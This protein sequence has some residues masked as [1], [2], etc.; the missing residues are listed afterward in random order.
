MHLHCVHTKINIPP[1][2]N[3]D[4]HTRQQ[5][6]V[7]V[8]TPLIMGASRGLSGHRPGRRVADSWGPVLVA[9]LSLN[10]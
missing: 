1:L 3:A 9:G 4:Q 10:K 8:I 7:T 5:H 2:N 6:H